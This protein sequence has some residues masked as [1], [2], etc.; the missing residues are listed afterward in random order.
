MS[1]ASR[2]RTSRKTRQREALREVFEQTTRPLTPF[3]ARVLAARQA[4]RLG[5][6]TVYRTIALWVNSGWLTPVTIAGEATRYERAELRHHHHF[7]CDRCGQVYDLPGCALKSKS[8]APDG[9][10]V[11][12][13]Q[14]TFFGLCRAC[15]RSNGAS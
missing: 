14:I 7:R 8:L 2:D 13:H 12:A 11:R 15:A 3:E 10:V 9:F 1:A 4:P 6:A 5:I